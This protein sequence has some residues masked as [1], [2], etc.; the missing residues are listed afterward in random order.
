MRPSITDVPD[1]LR[2]ARLLAVS[3]QD[4][5]CWRESACADPVF[6]T[7]VCRALRDEPHGIGLVTRSGVRALAAQV[8]PAIPPRL[9]QR[10]LVQAPEAWGF[11]AQGRMHRIASAT[12][13]RQT[14]DV[15]VARVKRLVEGAWRG[16]ALS[17]ID[18]TDGI[19]SAEITLGEGERAPAREV[20][21]DLLLEAERLDLRVHIAPLSDQPPRVLLAVRGDLGGAIASLCGRAGV[22]AERVAVLLGEVREGGSDPGPARDERSAAWFVGRSSPASL[23]PH[24]VRAPV[25]GPIAVEAVLRARGHGAKHAPIAVDLEPFC[26]GDPLAGLREGIG[27]T[28]ERGVQR[29]LDVAQEEGWR[30]L[31][32]LLGWLVPL[33]DDPDRTR[34]QAARALLDAFTRHVFADAAPLLRAFGAWLDDESTAHGGAPIVFLAEGARWLAEAVRTLRPSLRAHVLSVSSVVL[35]DAERTR[36]VFRD[37][38]LAAPRPLL[39]VD[40]GLGGTH[41]LAVRRHLAPL[42]VDV[43][44][45]MLHL[46][47]ERVEA[48]GPSAPVSGFNLSERCEGGDDKA[49]TFALAHV[50][51]EGLPRGQGSIAGWNEAG[52]DVFA[53]RQ[54]AW[55]VEIGR[56]VMGGGGGDAARR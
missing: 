19:A 16:R 31:D 53:R 17:W 12:W 42:G 15:L 24:V 23:P 33:G 28:P 46:T 44:G 48:L 26:D 43:R 51:D 27:L 47:P 54:A 21:H 50:L 39:V 13:P 32:T 56:G 45:A 6:A 7:L 3:L 29:L 37:A 52:E 2:D 35:R 34:S 5:L 30:A 10:L 49:R 8:V 18:A 25:T 11:D 36:A 40:A 1:A 55:A 14:N 22:G 20:A 4:G 38:C 41:P 9:R